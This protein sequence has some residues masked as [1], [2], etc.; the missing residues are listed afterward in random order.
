MLVAHPCTMTVYVFGIAAGGLEF[1]IF[2]I[3]AH[4]VDTLGLDFVSNMH[5]G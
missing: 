3:L 5:R 2:G 4:G 1:C